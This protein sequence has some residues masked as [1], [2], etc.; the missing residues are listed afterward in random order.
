V[1]GADWR[2]Q[3][4]GKVSSISFL[5]KHGYQDKNPDQSVRTEQGHNE[6]LILPHPLNR[7]GLDIA[8]R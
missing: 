5:E 7:E 2:L 3:E 8:H 4:S 6:N 1:L